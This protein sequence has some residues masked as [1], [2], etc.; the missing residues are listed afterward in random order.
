MFSIQIL[1]QVLIQK[2]K[3]HC[4]TVF[5]M[6]HIIESAYYRNEQNQPISRIAVLGI[7]SS[8]EFKR[9]FL[10][11]TI[12][13]NHKRVQSYITGTRIS[14]LK[15]NSIRSY[16]SDPPADL[17]TFTNLVQFLITLHEMK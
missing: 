11:A 8:R 13:P 2:L 15:Y 10:S 17:S 5:S 7:P 6:N 3:H 12:S 9:I 16:T 14:C 1:T 4:Q